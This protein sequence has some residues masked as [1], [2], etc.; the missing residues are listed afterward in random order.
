MLSFFDISIAYNEKNRIGE[1]GTFWAH[2]EVNDAM[3]EG[4]IIM[5]N[6]YLGEKANNHVFIL[7]KG[8]YVNITK[9]AKSLGSGENP[10]T[11]LEE[12]LSDTL[13]LSNSILAEKKWR[14]E[15]IE[16]VRNWFGIK[17]K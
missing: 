11:L 8:Q 16:Y 6:F 14:R 2:I 15:G 17:M 10:S 4:I 1:I 3:L 5:A 7:S 12:I 9:E 13:P